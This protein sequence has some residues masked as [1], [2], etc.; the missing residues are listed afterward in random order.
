MKSYCRRRSPTC[1]CR[2]SAGP[3]KRVLHWVECS[4]PGKDGAFY[5]IAHYVPYLDAHDRV[6]EVLGIGDDVT[7]QRC[8]EA[9]LRRQEDFRS[10]AETGPDIIARIDRQ[11]RHLYVNRRIEILTGMSA[12]LFLGKTDRELGMPP[13]L[14]RQ[15]DEIR[16]QVLLARQPVVKEFACRSPAGLRLRNVPDS[17]VRRRWRRGNNSDHH[18]RYF[19]A[20]ARARRNWPRVKSAFARRLNRPLWEFSW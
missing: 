14:V 7:R 16:E 12:E 6:S 4:F 5:F 2:T 8:A 20:E 9:K 10:L 18:A 3:S 15:W 19:R 11:G 17:R 1:T 13:D